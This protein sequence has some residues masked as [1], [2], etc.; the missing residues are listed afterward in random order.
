[1][2]ILKRAILCFTA[3]ISL[4]GCGYLNV[5][6][7]LGIDDENVF[8]T[9]SSFRS[10]F[11]W[12]YHTG[13][14]TNKESIFYAFPMYYD[15]LQKYSFSWYNTTDMSDAGKMGVTQQ[16]FK[17]GVITQDFLRSVTFDVNST[18]K[19]LAK[20]MFSIIRRCNITIAN[21]DRCADATEQEYNDL[22]GQAYALR[23]F[24]HFTLCRFFGGMPY[25]DHAI[26]ADESWDLE[27]ESVYDTYV[28][29]ATDLKKGYELMKEADYMRRNSVADLNSATLDE[30]N[31][32]AAVALYARALMY[33]ACEAGTDEAWKN[34]ADAAGLALNEVLEAGFSL[35]TKDKYTTNFIKQQ[36]TNENIWAYSIQMKDSHANLTS[37]MAY[38]QSGN[39]SGTSGVCPTQ[40]FVD[41][42]E[43]LNGMLL[44]TQEDRD[45]AAASGHYN[46]QDP[47]NNRDPRLDMTIVH[48]GTKT[49]GGTINIYYDPTDA[50][51]PVTQLNGMKLPFAIEW[52]TK[53]SDV[54]AYSNT[55]YYCMKYW[56]G[57]LG[58]KQTSDYYHVDP[59]VRLAEVYLNYAEAV[60]EA[61]GPSGVAPG[62]SLT[63]LQA[64]NIVRDRVGMPPLNV[65]DKENARMRIR[66]ERCVELAFEGHHYYH[67]IRRWDIASQ[68][69]GSTLYGIYV[70]KVPV[71]QE[72][73]NGKKYVRRAL[74]NNRQCVWKDYMRFIPFPDKEAFTMKNFKN[75]A[76]K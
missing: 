61:Y 49:T 32:A 42:Y 8:G 54:K 12:L 75:W 23:G 58:L 14:G 30:I 57:E 27:R 65:F 76:W 48:D 25:L 41:R 18:D 21:I 62:A 11:D 73:P 16:Y 66:N 29:A 22:L 20:A 74:P 2:K 5:D 43:T 40:N 35:V 37:I 4:S 24:C 50:T 52:G 45:A 10:Y 72:Y 3:M 26:E 38:P 69:M 70:E 71:S 15:F 33:A 6:P 17:Q 60:N 34:A 44:I 7:E 55:G 39:E 36:T 19:P 63:A 67:D 51:Y 53:D 13:D 28:N 9:Y 31:G 68:T 46:E 59:I 1:M 56:N 47:Y 64:V